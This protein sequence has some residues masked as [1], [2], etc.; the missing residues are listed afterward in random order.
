MLTGVLVEVS[1]EGVVMVATDSYRLAVRDL[2]A[3]ADGEGK[4]IVPERALT[5]AGRAAAAEEKGDRDLRW[6][7]A[8]VAFRIGDAH[9]HVATHR[10]RVPELSPAPARPAREPAHGL[11]PAVAGRRAP[12]GTPRPRH[13]AGAASSSTRSG[14]KLSSLQPRPRPGRRDRGGALR[15]R[16]PHGRVQPAVPGGR[17]HRCLRASR[18]DSTCATG[19]SPVWFAAT[20][21]SSP[22]S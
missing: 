21:T 7:S 15:G 9:A 18:S 19:S 17:A 4:A 16:G 6:T 11:A 14:V 2:V 5:E 1:R 12:R 13:H 10:R 22:T 8:Q 3:T 20:A